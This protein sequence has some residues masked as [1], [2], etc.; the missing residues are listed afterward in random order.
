MTDGETGQYTNGSD[1]LVC[2]EC[3]DCG[4]RRQKFRFDP[5]RHIGVVRCQECEADIFVV[6]LL[7]NKHVTTVKDPMAGDL[8]RQAYQDLKMRGVYHRQQS[9]LEVGQSD[10][11]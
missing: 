2:P 8:P 4:D 10:D 6:S 5:E 7:A 11:T 1:Y 9:R 3:P